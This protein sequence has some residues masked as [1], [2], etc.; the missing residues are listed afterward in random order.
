MFV[1]RAG[2]QTRTVT[3]FS[4]GYQDRA[5]DSNREA[6]PLDIRLSDEVGTLTVGP[7]PRVTYWNTDLRVVEDFLFR[8]SGNG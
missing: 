2:Q 4:L 8:S 3:S 7:N 1:F 5:P 6:A